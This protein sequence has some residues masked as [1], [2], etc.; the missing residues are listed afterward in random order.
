M[1]KIISAIA[2]TAIAT[3]LAISATV[4][5]AEAYYTAPS[6]PA[7]WG[8]WTVGSPKLDEATDISG[9]ETADGALKIWFPETATAT[10][11]NAI[12]NQGSGL[13]ELVAGDKLH[14]DA[15]L[16]GEPGA[17]D[18]RWFI[19]IAFNG[20]GTDPARFNIGKYIG[21][22]TGNPVLAANSYKQLPS[23]TYNVVLDIA[24]VIKS[25]DKDNGTNNYDKIFGEGG[26]SWLTTININIATNDPKNNSDKDNSLII[27]EIAIGGEDSFNDIETGT[28]TSSTSSTS[29]TAPTSSDNNTKPVSS[30]GNTTTNSSK[31]QVTTGENVLPIIGV[32]ALAVVAT[33]AVIVTKKRSK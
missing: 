5:S 25:Y 26:N 13:V 8:T 4:A 3:S 12:I 20:A 2:A 14:I 29:S 10:I 1:K 11:P 9:E 6:D 33:S 22:A 7:E 24:E 17:T 19:E 16:E 18:M 23:G 21:E 27:R 32:T 30:K 28:G 15:T 31:G